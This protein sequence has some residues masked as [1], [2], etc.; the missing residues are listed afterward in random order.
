MNLLSLIQ[1]VV[2]TAASQQRV[3][4]S[5]PSW[6]HLCLHVLPVY[7][8]VLPGFSGFLPPPRNMH[9]RLTAD[10]E[11]SRGVSVDGCVSL[12]GLV[13][14]WRPVQVCPASDP[15]TA[16]IGSTPPVT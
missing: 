9:V 15:V 10:C 14:D 11:L 4:G 16:G 1:P 2:S 3:P 8:W 7:A 13:M 12:C 6:F 5:D